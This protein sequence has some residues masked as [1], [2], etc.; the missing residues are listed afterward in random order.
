MC[1]AGVVCMTGLDFLKVQ[2]YIREQEE[3][4]MRLIDL[5]PVAAE[6]LQ[7]GVGVTDHGYSVTTGPCYNMCYHQTNTQAFE[8]LC[9][10][11]CT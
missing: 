6:A 7:Q 2:V 1:V 5:T 10:Y 4:V 11:A 8:Y 3:G 9:R